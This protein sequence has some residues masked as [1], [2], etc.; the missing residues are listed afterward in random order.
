M[1]HNPRK[2][3]VRQ[4]SFNGE[5][6]NAWFRVYAHD[7]SYEDFPATLAES[8][9]HQ[10]KKRAYAYYD[11]PDTRAVVVLSSNKSRVIFSVRNMP[12]RPSEGGDP[13]WTK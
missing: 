3:P 11:L 7:G 8:R 1:R 2:Y 13:R 9:G 10:M 12:K 4:D 5:L 6:A